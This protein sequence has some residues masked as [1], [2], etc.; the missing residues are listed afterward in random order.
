MNK[1]IRKINKRTRA[2]DDHGIRAVL[3]DLDGVLVDAADWHKDALNDALELFGY[4]PIEKKEHFKTFNGLSTK[5]KLDM[6]FNI[7]RIDNECWND[8]IAEKKQELTVKIINE[9]CVPVQRIIDT[10]ELANKL[11]NGQTAVVTN[12]SRPTAE[13][14]LEKSGLLHLFKFLICNEDV[15]GKIKPH[16]LPYILATERFGLKQNESLAI[17]DTSRGIMSAI[18]AKCRI[19]RL[20]SFDDLTPSKLINT[21]DSYRITI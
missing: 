2:L 6:L 12:C 10:V 19:W 3:F 16:P 9:R 17:D 18:D 4:A 1:V 13:L 5:R 14:M 11:F 8:S 20:K 21:L 7:G 15:S